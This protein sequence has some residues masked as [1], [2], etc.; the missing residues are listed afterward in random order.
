MP[1]LAGS[2]WLSWVNSEI[3]SAYFKS[4]VLCHFAGLVKGFGGIEFGAYA[5]SVAQGVAVHVGEA[6]EVLL[7]LIN[8]PFPRMSLVWLAKLGLIRPLA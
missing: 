5:G 1:D 3:D 2:Y 6:A 4:F 7:A 8:S